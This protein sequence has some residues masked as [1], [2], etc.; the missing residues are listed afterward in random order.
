MRFAL[1]AAA[2]WIVASLLAGCASLTTL[3]EPFRDETVAE[4]KEETAP[5]APPE[6]DVY[7][8]EIVAPE[9]L[10]SLLE[11]HLDLAR[12]RDARVAGAVTRLELDRLIAGAPAQARAL[13]ET[14]GY[15][16][17][18]VS[19][20][21]DREAVP[22]VRVVVEPG[23]RARIAS[24]AFSFEGPLQE[25][26]AAGDEAARRTMAMV[27]DGWPLAQGAAFS[28]S[29]WAGA[30][31]TTL[32]RLQGAGYALARW[33]DTSATVN[34][35][36][37]SVALTRAGHSGPLFRSGQVRLVGVGRVEET[38]VLN[39]L[40]F[41]P[42]E[43]YS[44][45]LLAA[46]QRNLQR[47]EL[48][49]AASV[50]LLVEPE[51][52]GDATVLVKV[53]EHRLQ[54]ATVGIGY[55][56]DTGPRMTLDHMHR[57]PFGWDVT[58]TNKLQIG[59]AERLDRAGHLAPPAE[60]LP[61]SGF[62]RLRAPGPE[63]RVAHLGQRASGPHAGHRR[64]RA[65]VLRRR[66]GRAG[67]E[68]GAD[69]LGMGR[70]AQLQRRCAPHRQHRAADTRL[71]PVRRDRRRLLVSYHREQRLA[72]AS[73]RARD[74]LPPVVGA[75]LPAGLPGTRPG[76][77]PIRHRH[78]GHAAVS[79]RRA[80][81]GARLRLPLARPGRKR[82]RHQRTHALHVERRACG[83]ISDRFRPSGAPVDVGNAANQW[84]ELKPVV[85]VGPGIRWRS[86]VGALRV[87]LAYGIDD[88]RWRLEV[89][90]GIAP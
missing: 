43:R 88:R 40:D 17:A 14:E 52:A 66:P 56:S 55:S 57:L 8:L 86:P 69:H 38:A 77:R 80:G 45:G 34:V 37:H 78:P 27:E 28:Q 46:W 90:L 71:R 44:E 81:F 61:R 35:A 51:H 24:V 30:K 48:F 42:G 53:K 85:G 58:V 31:N 63:R 16:E 25:A 82:R 73:A 72:R 6:A 23:P 62:R 65:P 3:F 47:S 83:P 87:D 84:S 26:A 75:A 4:A 67:R 13:A 12:F 68:R 41:K 50:T 21:R 20:S 54:Q 29:A 9:P 39:L 60:P 18:Q 2:A 89:S 32:A 49:E 1:R 7:R 33:Q 79:R 36:E 76:L 19:A 15:F 64:L 22:L 5:E 10:R 11:R 70:D 74:G 59:G